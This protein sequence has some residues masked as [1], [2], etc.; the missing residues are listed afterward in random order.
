[1][2]I[3]R[4]YVQNWTRL[5]SRLLLQRRSEERI[6]GSLFLISSIMSLLK[7]LLQN[8][9]SLK[10]LMSLT[11][12]I[13]GP[14]LVGNEFINQIQT[15]SSKRLK[16]N[17]FA[18]AN[19]RKMIY[20]PKEVG[21]YKQL[22][23]QEG[24]PTD[25]PTLVSK[26]KS[27]P[28]PIIVDCTASQQIANLYG[29]WLSSG[30]H[31]VTPNKKAFSGSMESWNNLFSI[32]EANSVSLL[33]ESTVGAGLPVLSTLRDL[34]NTGDEIV[35]IEGILS[36]T[37][38]YL[39]NNFSDPSKKAEFSSVVEK[40]KSLGY[41]EPDPRDDL[42]GLDVARKVVIL[43]RIAG[44]PLDISS[45]PIDSIIPRELSSLKTPQE[46][47]TRLPE[48]NKHFQDLNNAALEKGHVL[49][50]VGVVQSKGSGVY[51]RSYPLDHPFASLKGS[52]NIIAFK[53]RR[54][55]SPLII[56]GAGAGSE[57]TAFGMFSDCKLFYL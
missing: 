47:L 43:G 25:L 48:Y 24:I 13:I 7:H 42:N 26:L 38:S 2:Q 3:K 57:V 19:S 50:F 53:T 49:R 4:C 32:A 39:F 10:N 55:P 28:N 33:H 18:I 17:I 8:H 11:V 6:M 44:Y 14:G 29:S 36:G 23:D 22:L 27:Q 1:M 45:L 9:F 20:S 12:A 37:L 34:I 21:P 54:F 15:F 16:I 35:S 52:D 51:L 46:F 5:T 30:L 40:A 31:V 56:Q 41:T